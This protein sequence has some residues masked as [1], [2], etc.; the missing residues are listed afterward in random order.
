MIAV[1]VMNGATGQEVVEHEQHAFPQDVPAGGYSGITW[2]GESKYAVVSDNGDDGFFIFDIQL[3]SLG[4][5]TSVKNLGFYG[6]GDKNHDN[7][8]IALFTPNNTLF[9]SGE[10]DNAVREFDLNGKT[11]GRSLKMPEVFAG[12]SRA[13]GLEAL[14]YNSVTHR[15][16]T[17][18]ESTLPA[19]GQR[20]DATNGVANRLR[21]VAFDDSLNVV[22]QFPYIMDTSIDAIDAIEA[23]DDIDDTEN[24]GE[25]KFENFAFGVSAL[26]AL[27][28]GKVLVLEREFAVPESKLGAYVNCKIYEVNPDMKS[29]G[30]ECHKCDGKAGNHDCKGK[31]AVL[32]WDTPLEKTLVAEW[33]TAIGMFDFSIANYEGM[34]LGPKL[35][36]GGQTIILISDSQNR[37]ANIL[38]DYFKSFVIR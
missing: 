29:V 8:G 3:D 13:Y 27:D 30:K 38:S 2:L 17:T 35:P 15:F 26:A 16:W 36:D 14:T 19:D 4:E 25:I 11:T 31:S 9:I 10:K 23:I 18:S 34:C 7:E 6:N 32:Q 37:Y 20:A 12:A 22:A 5:I 33:M 1:I 21:L 24:A 28:N